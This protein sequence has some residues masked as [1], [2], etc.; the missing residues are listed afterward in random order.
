MGRVDRI[1]I[2]LERPSGVF[3]AGEVVRVHVTFVVSGD[4][5]CRGLQLHL[6]GKARVHWHTGSGDDR[7]DYDGKTV[8]QNQRLTLHGSYFKTGLLDEAGGDA[9]FGR[10]HG[11]GTVYIPC[12]NNDTNMMILAVRVMDYD[13]GKK[14]DLLGEVVINAADVV[15][16]GQMQSFPL[17]RNG[18][19]EKGEVVLSAKFVPFES[20]FPIVGRSGLQAST[21][22]I[23]SQCLVLTVH[24]VSF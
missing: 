4:V 12:D 2:N 15:R 6:T 22:A 3:Y 21:N 24:S 8:F 13:W 11:D 1:S 17:S 16:S 9:Y 19:P 20:L 23:K 5:V 14:D 18:R 10:S 7:K